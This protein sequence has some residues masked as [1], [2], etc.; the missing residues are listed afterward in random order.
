LQEG[1]GAFFGNRS[2]V[3]HFANTTRIACANFSYIGE[4]GSPGNVTVYNNNN[5][6][7]N[8]NNTSMRGGPTSA[9]TSVNNTATMT[10]SSAKGA[11]GASTGTTAAPAMLQT[12][13]GEGL[14]TATSRV[15]TLLLLFSLL[16]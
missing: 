6:N 12:N 10:V 9:V 13:G 14:V 5:N 4:A 15:W 8:N 7:N 1:L 11:K 16:V 3:V 2:F